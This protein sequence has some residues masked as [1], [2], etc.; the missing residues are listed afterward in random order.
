MNT[1]ITEVLVALTCI[2][3]IIAGALY[4]HAHV[5]WGCLF[6]TCAFITH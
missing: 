1:T 4:I 5:S 6:G 3:G 2:V